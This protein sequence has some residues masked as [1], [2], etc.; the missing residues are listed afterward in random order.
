MRSAGQS[1]S[2]ARSSACAMRDALGAVDLGEAAGQHRLGLVIERAQEL[3][4]PAVPDAG[5][6]RADVGGGEDGQKL[7]AAPATA[8]PRRNSRWSCG[9]TGRATAPPS[10]SRDAARPAR[11]PCRSRRATG[12]SAGRTRARCARRRS[13]GPRCGP[14]RCRAETARHRAAC[15]AP[16]WIFR[17]RS[18]A[19]AKLLAGRRAR[20]RRGCR[21][22]AADAR[23]PC[24]GGTC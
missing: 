23:P 2:S 21:C 11:P 5:A 3:R 4:L 8:P 18:L 20:C 22:S 12:R 24:S 10:T 13:N 7:H 1:L 15:G 6:D 14:W 19:S 9:R 17:I 16:A